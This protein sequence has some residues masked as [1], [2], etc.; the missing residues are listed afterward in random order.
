MKFPFLVL[1]ISIGF[2]LGLQAQTAE[3]MIE[4]LKALRD[5]TKQSQD[6]ALGNAI[7]QIN[8]A[9]S[10]ATK[11]LSFYEEA[12]RAVRFEGAS[13][14]SQKFR[15]WQDKEKD[16]LRASLT[17]EA[18]Q[19]HLRHLALTLE[20]SRVEDPATVAPRVNE[21]LS[22]AI[23]LRQQMAGADGNNRLAREMLMNPVQGGIFSQ[24]MQ[25]GGYIDPGPNWEMS[26]GNIP[27]V[28][29]KMVRPPLLEQKSPQL[30]QTWDYQIN[31]EESLA[32]EEEL[33]SDK[34]EWTNRRKPELLWD[35]AKARVDIGQTAQGV[36]EM[37]AILEANTLHPSF[38]DW[39]GELE[40]IIVAASSPQPPE[41]ETPETEAP[42]EQP[43]SSRSASQAPVAAT[44]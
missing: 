28:L 6:A 32:E 7:R 30:I 39:A 12:V 25:L 34:L 3:Q 17:R 22:G 37:F 20:A 14:D 21:L 5:R 1:A 31:F 33:Q 23:E 16:N 4:K 18:I 26:I 13:H 27:G 10:T 44:P 35:R 24:W 8:D 40:E 2:P 41:T 29:D 9:G 19:L 42:D 36:N 38:E 11:A 43:T 15:E